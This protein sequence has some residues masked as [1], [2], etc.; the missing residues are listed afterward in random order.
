MLPSLARAGAA[1]ALAVAFVPAAAAAQQA[2]SYHLA[3]SET[4]GAGAGAAA[5]DL[6]LTIGADGSIAGIY[7]ALD[8]GRPQDVT[9][10]HGRGQGDVQ[11]AQRVHP[12]DACDGGAGVGQSE[13]PVRDDAGQARFLGV[14]VLDVHQVRPR[15]VEGDRPPVVAAA[16]A[17][18]RHPLGQFAEVVV[19][20]KQDVDPPQTQRPLPP[21]CA[22]GWSS[23]DRW[24]SSPPFGR[25]T[26]TN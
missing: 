21:P 3:L 18:V 22:D 10:E 5:A 24:W 12:R 20:R 8:G 2:G 7:R 13:R 15:V 16:D 4:T 14:G 1:L 23:R 19:T 25:A 9:G 26:D 6:R 11:A 17:V